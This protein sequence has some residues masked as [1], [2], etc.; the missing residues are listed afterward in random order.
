MTVEWWVDEDDLKTRTRTGG[1]NAINGFEFQKAYARL[2]VAWMLLGRHGIV[3][4]RYEGAQDVD[5][6]FGD[7]RQQFVQA[8]HYSADLSVDDLHEVMAGFSRDVISA[9]A[10]GC[11]D[12]SLPLFRLVSTRT[13][14]Q[15]DG[16]EVFRG[17]WP[18]RHENS[19]MAKIKP[20]YRDNLSDQQVLECVNLAWERTSFEVVLRDDAVRDFYDQA[21]WALAEFGVPFEHVHASLGRI[22]QLLRPT[23]SLQINDVA[24]VL[25]C[26]PDGH[27]GLAHGACR[28]LPCMRTLPDKDK[29]NAAFLGGGASP[30]WAAAAYGLGVKRTVTS[31]IEKQLE[32][33]FKKGGMLLIEGRSGTGK[34]ILAR[35]IAWDLHRHGTCVVL[36]VFSPDGM[37]VDH[38]VAITRLCDLSRRPVL[39]VVDE[40]WRS[41]SFF[42]DL[43]RHA[44]ER[45]C[46]LSTSQPGQQPETASAHIDL[47][48]V[49]LGALDKEEESGLQTLLGCTT[50]PPGS[51]KSLA[52]FA[53]GGQIFA[54]LLALQNGSLERFAARMVE[55]FRADPNHLNG[56]IDLCTA[57]IYDQTIATSILLQR[58]PNVDPFWTS[59]LF[60]DLVFLR[61]DRGFPRL[62]ISHA[63]VAAEVLKHLQ[64]D[65]VP[66][67]VS[68][69]QS[70]TATVREERLFTLR[71]LTNFIRD[72]Q[73]SLACANSREEIAAVL[74]GF[75]V[76]GTYSDLHRMH[77]ILAALG[78]TSQ[79]KHC[80][81]LATNDR[82]R[83]PRDINLALTRQA[84]ATFGPVF[85][86]VF[87]V[88]EADATHLGRRKFLDTT[89]EWGTPE[90]LQQLVNQTAFWLQE[91]QFP[92]EE[93][94]HL[95][96]IGA[97][98]ALDLAKRMV[99]LL[100]AY[101]LAPKAP[102]E[103]S[104]AAV[105]LLIR[106]MLPEY[107]PA[108][109]QRA[110]ADLVTLTSWTG[111]QMLLVIKLASLS[112]KWSD[113][114]VKSTTCEQLMMIFSKAP[115]HPLNVRLVRT[116]VNL[117]SIEHLG[118]LQELLE[119]LLANHATQ[120]VNTLYQQ[121]ESR[122]SALSAVKSTVSPAVPGR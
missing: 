81:A 13:P 88:Y 44:G 36:D 5:I 39:L 61:N 112:A 14:S 71:L 83:E 101:A 55:P 40:V 12:A 116:M 31:A 43:N 66:R 41:N 9:K 115:D 49:P 11:S 64:I 21:C 60:K 6:R 98:G 7:G 67:A 103:T 100:N 97:Y 73:H 108:L 51:R 37:T 23:V 85:D 77:R 63:L 78:K 94:R 120:E 80:M 107:L 113:E 34:S 121:F 15:P 90:Q 118:A 10:R 46:V 75:E 105:R 27:F 48:T 86:T 2:R 54:F 8:K 72:P 111:D 50:L 117:A 82:I 84:A 58:Y 53:R 96:D 110:M 74:K 79:A 1:V 70:C 24:T 102:V 106:T 59:P 56:F 16:L 28:L 33:L 32:G 17:V 29:V 114:A 87:A 20:E 26:L 122:A 30:P 92:A 38:W 25:E 62:Q 109:Q 45:L 95:F 47:Y 76:A 69:C 3:E 119:Q 99:P 42:E 91:Q 19:I 18:A 35:R 22:D 57:G 65:P 89:R 93:T 4:V 52:E 104:L 68:L